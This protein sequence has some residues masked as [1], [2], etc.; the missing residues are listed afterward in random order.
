MTKKTET[1]EK[2]ENQKSA[3]LKTLVSTLLMV[4]LGVLLLLRPDFATAT[5]ASVL[6][7]ILLGG[8]AILITVT[9]LNWNTMGLK[10]LI[11]GIIAAAAGIFIVIRPDFLASLFGVIIGIYLGFQGISTLIDALKLQKSGKM[12]LPTLIV[13]LVQV[14]LA[15][16]LCFVPMGITWLLRIIGALMILS[17]LSDLVLGS[18]YFSNLPKKEKKP[19]EP[20]QDD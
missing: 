1:P 9:I 8:G 4:A 15:L 18:R 13:G 6:G 14:G 17:G 11:V 19:A 5:V 12:Y 16:A 10:E 2:N 3:L 20:E 7:W